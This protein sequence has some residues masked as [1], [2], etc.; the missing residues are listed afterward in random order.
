MDKSYTKV[1]VNPAAGANSTQRKWP[2]IKSCL[3]RIGLSFDFQF[4]EGRGHGIELAKAAASDGYRNFIAVGGDGTVH[5]VANGILQTPNASQTVLGMVCTGTGS[6][7][8]RSIGIPHNYSQACNSLT[9]NR[10]MVIDVGSVE[11]THKGQR[12]QRYFVNSAGIGIDAAVTEATE[13]LPKYFGGTIP[14]LIGLVRSFTG[15]RNKQVSFRIGTGPLEKARV[16]SM[17]IANGGYFGGGMRIAPEAKLDDR[18][19]DIVIINDFSKVDLLKNISRV[20]KGT[21]LT[22]PK[23]RLERADGITIE[24][25]QKFLLQADGEFLGEGPVSLSLLPGALSLAV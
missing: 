11:Y 13:K 21:H 2:G 1:I 20:Y 18:L 10:R 6:D 17:V 14:Y 5:E 7:L 3:K 4:T 24:S 8:S 9:S 22:H 19:F 25:N 15:Y 12:A 23:V 16:L